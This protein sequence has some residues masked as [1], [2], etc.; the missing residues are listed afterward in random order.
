MKEMKEG[1]GG[2]GDLAF[3]T[4]MVAQRVQASLDEPANI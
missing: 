1:G 2:G 4:T 3:I